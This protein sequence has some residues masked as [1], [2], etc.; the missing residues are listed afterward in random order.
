MRYYHPFG[1]LGLK[2]VSLAIAVLLW[3]TV[4]GQQTVE[5]GLRV[6]LE[7]HNLPEKLEIVDQPPDFVDVRLRGGSGA[8]S[9]LAPGDVVAIIDV[10][11]ARPGRRLFN[12]SGEQVRTPFGIDVS[13]VA[14]PTLTLSFEVADTKQVPVVPA[15][16]GEPA[17]GFVRGKTSADPGT[18]D[19]VGPRSAIARVTEALTEPVDIEG[20]EADRTDSVT[21]GV[22]DPSVRLKT[23][24][25]AQVTVQIV[26]APIEHDIEG[27][28]VRIRGLGPSLSARAE[29]IVVT[30]RVRGPKGSVERLAADAVT[31]YVDV[32]GLGPGR[33]TLPVHVDPTREFGVARIDP[34]DVTITIR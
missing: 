6:P 5:R 2:I 34:T 9:R 22:T 1:H 28:P 18:V 15:V 25:S 13:Q 32:T 16:D 8:L 3:L 21:I 23:P 27:T 33:Y 12:L 30:V 14:P 7:I 11:S 10:K 31:V 29:P 26:P 17:P 20:A 19:V 24:G 4:S